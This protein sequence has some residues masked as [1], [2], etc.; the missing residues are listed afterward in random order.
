MR[1]GI[2]TNLFG[3][4]FRVRVHG[5]MRCCGREIFR[6]LNF[7]LYRKTSWCCNR[8]VSNVCQ[9][10]LPCMCVTLVV[11]RWSCSTNRAALLCIFPVCQ[12]YSGYVGS[13]L[14]IHIL[15]SVLLAYCRLPP[16]LS[17]WRDI[18]F[19][20][21]DQVSWQIWMLCLVYA[22]SRI[23]WHLWLRPDMVEN[24]FE[25]WAGLRWYRWIR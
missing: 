11:R 10:S 16:L 25:R 1:V 15:I 22:C 24:L 8:R 5:T 23:V 14:L 3:S 21:V 20:W 12:C 4:L 19:V 18:G 17:V 7:I 9:P 6:R 2:W 13:R